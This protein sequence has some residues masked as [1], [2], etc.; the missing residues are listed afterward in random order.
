MKNEGFLE[1]SFAPRAQFHLQ[2]LCVWI[3]GGI[4]LISI[5][6]GSLHG[7][8]SN[9]YFLPVFHLLPWFTGYMERKRYLK[10]TLT[11]A[12]G[13]PTEVTP[14]Q[15]IIRTLWGTYAALIAVELTLRVR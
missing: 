10:S 4:L 14:E 3:S 8:A 9:L 6:R 12:A 13:H 15:S 2:T 11:K 7:L 1:E 5:V